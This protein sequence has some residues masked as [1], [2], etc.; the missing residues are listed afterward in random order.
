MDPPT[1]INILAELALPPG[2][3]RET[4]ASCI[5]QLEIH[6][7]GHS[8]PAIASAPIA[9]SPNDYFLLIGQL[10]RLAASAFAN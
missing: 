8:L 10:V 6:P 3:P 9:N 4:A 1:Q 2:D 7:F 5:R